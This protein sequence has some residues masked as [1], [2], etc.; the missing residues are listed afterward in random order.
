ML[1]SE[2]VTTGVAEPAGIPQPT[3]TS[4]TLVGEQDRLRE[5]RPHALERRKLRPKKGR[6]LR[7]PQSERGQSRDRVCAVDDP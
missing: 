1:E 6:D 5:G 4:E 3:H 7:K 2:Y